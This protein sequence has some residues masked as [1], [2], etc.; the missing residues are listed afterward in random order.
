MSELPD[1]PPF[2]L[3]A[4]VLTPLGAGG[5]RYEPDGRVDVDAAGR[6]AAVEPWSAAADG[7]APRPEPERSTCGRSWCCP[8]WSTSTSTCRSSRT[9]ASAPGS[10]C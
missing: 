9:P 1:R 3:R 2:T 5:S 6:I 8:G 4:R 10:T 7:A